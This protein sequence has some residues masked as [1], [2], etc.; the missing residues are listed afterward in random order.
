MVFSL[1]TL[2]P[3]MLHELTHAILSAPYAEQIGI[4]FENPDTSLG[5]ECRVIYKD[6]APRWAVVLGHLGPLIVG[7]LLTVVGVG[8][9]VV[10][11]FSA[12]ETPIQWLKLS[13]AA[14]WYAI[15]LGPSL[16]DLDINTGQPAAE[17]D[18]RGNT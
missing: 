7:T 5:A 11:G 9:V 16:E 6:S 4:V 1:V 18:K 12:P 14:V 15:Y 2:P 17:Q 8:W 10:S 3:T 13:I